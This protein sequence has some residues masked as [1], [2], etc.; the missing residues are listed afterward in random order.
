VTSLSQHQYCNEVLWTRARQVTFPF[1]DENVMEIHCFIVP[2][3]K[4]DSTSCD[5][6]RHTYAISYCKLS[7]YVDL[8]NSYS[9][10]WWGEII[11]FLQSYKF[12]ERLVGIF[13]ISSCLH[14]QYFNSNKQNK[15]HGLSPRANYTDRATAACRRRDCQLLR[16]K[17]A[18]WSAWRIPSGVFSVF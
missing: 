16:I 17:G 4:Q 15:L 18:K 9:I 12:L 11:T 2:S 8:K 6:D 7:A 1:L 3:L 14:V 13:W 5:G 10:I